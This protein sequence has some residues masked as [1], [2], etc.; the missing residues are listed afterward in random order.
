MRLNGIDGLKGLKIDDCEQR[1][2][3]A[4]NEETTRDQRRNRSRK[5][6][7]RSRSLRAADLSVQQ[8]LDE[9]QRTAAYCLPSG[10]RVFRVSSF[11]FPVSSFEFRT[12]SEQT[13]RG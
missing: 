7:G 6:E 8:I 10:S 1:Q 13:Q 2:E 9:S 3:A 12:A 4:K 5:Q 11:Q